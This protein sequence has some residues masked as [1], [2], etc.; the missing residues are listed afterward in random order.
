[1]SQK[2]PTQP[3][4]GQVSQLDSELVYEGFCSIKKISLQHSLF[5][6]EYSDVL[7]REV[8][9]SSRVVG[10]LLYDPVL[11]NILM[12]EQFRAGV[13]A[14]SDD[15]WIMEIIAGRVDA[16]ESWESCAKREVL[17]EAQ[18][19]MTTL[20]PIVEY[21]PSPG[22]CNEYVKLYCGVFDSTQCEHQR[23]C[24]VIEEQEDIRTCLMPV[25]EVFQSLKSGKINNGAS[26]I[27]LQW[28]YIHYEDISSETSI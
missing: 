20:I 3:F 24:G 9:L 5:N 22:V 16:S 19:V 26:L 27:A 10:V 13:Y 25:D 8:V 15:P 18:C 12:I 1:M 28:L 6:G 14:A 11:K 2:T 21:Y 17:E 23:I 4:K 7:T